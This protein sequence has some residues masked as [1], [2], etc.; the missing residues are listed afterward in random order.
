[1][2]PSRLVKHIKA[3]ITFLIEVIKVGDLDYIPTI[4]TRICA[5][6]S[7]QIVGPFQLSRLFTMFHDSM[8]WLHVYYYYY[9]YYY[10]NFI[11]L[12]TN[13]IFFPRFF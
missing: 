10:V 12:A 4:L 3:Y 5:W 1:M 8:K 11:I 2:E 9:Y 6:K 7:N 13:M